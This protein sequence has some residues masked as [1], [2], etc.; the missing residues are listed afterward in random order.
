MAGS[1]VIRPLRFCFVEMGIWSILVVGFGFC[2]AICDTGGLQM[3]DSH[4]LFFSA[5]DPRYKTNQPNKKLHNTP[6]HTLS[7]K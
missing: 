2:W 3:G 5:A 1:E 6:L 4:H 7:S